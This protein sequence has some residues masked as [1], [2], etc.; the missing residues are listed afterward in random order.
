[1]ERNF[2]FP[3]EKK[4][5]SFM[6]SY[7]INKLFL[8]LFFWFNCAAAQ[9]IAG[10]HYTAAGELPNNAVRSLLVD[11]NNILW[12]GT[13][14]GVVKKENDIFKYFFEEDGLALNSC[15]AIAEDRNRNLWFGSYGGGL[16]IYD[17]FRFKVIS[18]EDGLVHNEITK[19]YSRGNR[20]YVGTSDGVSV[21]D[22]ENFEVVTPE[23][24]SGE[25]LF[26]VQDFFEYGDQIY[27]VTYNSG[28]FR[29]DG[30][31][32][33]TG[34]LKINDHEYIYSVQVENDSIYSSNKGFYT[35]H[36]LSEYVKQEA[37]LSAA[38]KQ[39]TSIIWD[40][41]VTSA[42][43]IFVAAWGIYDSDGGIYELVDGQM[44]SRASEFGI[45]SREVISLAFCSSNF[46][47]WL[48]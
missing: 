19:L 45:P 1:M 13:E 34:L 35:R 26:R 32:G 3:F 25:E 18:A 2:R 20:M 39:G 29:I 11:S 43:R 41:V 14:N 17:G 46:R 10:R 9:N 42:E 6:P 28:I 31:A 8:L 33:K 23:I 22:I 4:K 30:N 12:I 44:V 24:P 47:F 37:D 27:V 21:V 48:I 7:R 15:W 40:Y 38:E 36:A 5:N 16:S